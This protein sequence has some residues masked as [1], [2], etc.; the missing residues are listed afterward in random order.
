[1]SCV[2][3]P[4]LAPATI[5]DLA[6]Q[7]RIEEAIREQIFLQLHQELP[8]TIFQRNITMVDVEDGAVEVAQALVVKS[9]AQKRMVTGKDGIVVLK[10]QENLGRCSQRR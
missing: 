5:T 7:K 10:L 2:A 1:M 9:N 6:L 8:Y 4:V 3:I